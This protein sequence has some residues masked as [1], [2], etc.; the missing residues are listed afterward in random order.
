L[1][2]RR[3][4]QTPEFNLG[5]FAF[6]LNLV[7]EFWQIPFFVGMGEGPHWAGVKICTQSALGDVAILMTAFWVTAIA[8]RSRNWI[9]LPRRQDVAIFLGIGLI[10][11]ALFESVATGPAG[12]WSYTIAM[13]RLPIIGTGLLPLLQWLVI[14]L[15]VLWFARRQINGDPLRRRPD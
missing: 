11:T 15:L 14:P 13:P 2:P 4:L 10:A 9:L 8:A 12:R 7:W 1:N 5:V 3:L 6:L